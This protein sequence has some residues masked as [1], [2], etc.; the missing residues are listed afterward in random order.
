MLRH[1]FV[2][3]NERAFLIRKGRFEDIFGPGNYWIA[4]FRI[5]IERHD[6]NKIVLFSEW[7]DFLVKERWELMSRYFIDVETDHSEVAVVYFDDKVSRVIGPGCRV[8]FWRGRV[9]VTYDL[10]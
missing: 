6:V 2:G 5:S 4:G 10:I 3:D 7:T 9:E 8:L 1:V